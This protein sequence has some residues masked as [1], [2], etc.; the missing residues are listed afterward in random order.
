MIAAFRKPKSLVRDK[1]GS[2]AVEMA[3]TMTVIGM[4]IVGTFEI[5]GLVFEQMQLEK[6]VQ[7]GAHFALLSQ[8]EAN[9]AA[10]II[11]IVEREVGDLS[12]LTVSVTNSC[13]CPGE[14]TVDCLD[15][16]DDDSIPEVNMV[17]VATKTVAVLNNILPRD[18]YILRAEAWVRAR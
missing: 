6:A 3:L 16:C 1:R 14:G 8:T 2:V 10:A 5:S 9:D 12:N 13:S 7:S 15:D 17:V 18:Q 4:L 11:A